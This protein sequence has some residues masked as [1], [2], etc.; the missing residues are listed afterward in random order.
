M[1]KAYKP[2]LYLPVKD[3]IAR[4]QED[5]T[6]Y[7]EMTMGESRIIEEITL[8]KDAGEV[9]FVHLPE[10]KTEMVNVLH[11]NP[12]AVEYFLRNVG[13]ERISLQIPK[14]LLDGTYEKKFKHAQEE[15]KKRRGI[16]Q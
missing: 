4:D 1:E 3:V 10:K 11:R 8:D 6:I 16:K 2:D 7:R 13:G 14:Q 9:R 5:G 12:L 15:S